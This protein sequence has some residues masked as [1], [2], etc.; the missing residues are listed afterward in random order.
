MEGHIGGWHYLWCIVFYLGA[1]CLT[2]TIS[3]Y[4]LVIYEKLENII[5]LDLN[6]KELLFAIW[7][8]ISLRIDWLGN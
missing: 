2:N 5:G 4:L 3:I 6:S 7:I 1:L 8:F